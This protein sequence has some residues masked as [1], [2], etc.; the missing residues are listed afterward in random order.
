MELEQMAPSYHYQKMLIYFEFV[1]LDN[2]YA[3]AIQKIYQTLSKVYVDVKSNASSY[4]ILHHFI[5]E[6][7]ISILHR[8]RIQISLDTLHILSSFTSCK[9]DE[10]FMF[11]CY[12]WLRSR[13][14][15]FCF[16]FLFGII[17]ISDIGLMWLLAFR[18]G[19]GN[20]TSGFYRKLDSKWNWLMKFN[21]SK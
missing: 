16:S 1:V 10:K 5:P 11:F 7:C 15:F 8:I 18:S 9:I 6:R 13:L 4:N 21:L 19:F 3:N 14:K 2:F 12:Y 20:L 17:H